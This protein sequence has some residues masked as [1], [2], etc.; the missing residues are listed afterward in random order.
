MVCGSNPAGD[1]LDLTGNPWPGEYRRN[2]GKRN[3]M[4][5]VPGSPPDV[6]VTTV[7]EDP[8]H[9]GALVGSL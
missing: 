5:S 2:A 3:T 7:L 9:R 8:Y 4:G 1:L 6:V